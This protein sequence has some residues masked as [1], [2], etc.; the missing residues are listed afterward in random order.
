MTNGYRH[1][2]DDGWRERTREEWEQL[3]MQVTGGGEKFVSLLPSCG[4]GVVSGRGDS[5]DGRSRWSSVVSADLFLI[6]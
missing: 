6:P 2:V 4:D 3:V 1:S 5:A